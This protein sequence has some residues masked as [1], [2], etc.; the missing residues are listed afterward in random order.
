MVILIIGFA[1][2]FCFSVVFRLLFTHPISTVYFAF[3]DLF[4]YCVHRDWNL[5]R[6]GSL[7]AYCAHFGGGKTLSIVHYVDA[8]FRRYNNVRVWDSAQKR[9]VLQKIHI[10]SN[11]DLKSVPY[12]PLV[13]LSQVVACGFHNRKIDRENGTRTVVLVILDEA[14]SQLNSRNFKSNIDPAFLNT[15]ITSRHYHISFLYSTQK[16]RLTDA[17]MR[18]VTQRCIVCNKIWRFMI[19]SIYDADEIEIASDPSMVKPLRRTGF[20]IRDKDYL[21]YDTLAVVGSLKRSVDSGDMMSEHEILELRGN[22]N[23]DDGNVS[24]PSRKLLK[25]RKASLRG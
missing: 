24:R 6:A 12:E 3:L 25:R 16:F 13:S 15:L 11:V 14:S 9:F 20:F 2:M 21:A 10:I 8:V 7:N 19:Q 22:L 4:R 5:L 17:L 1:F 23:P 18:S